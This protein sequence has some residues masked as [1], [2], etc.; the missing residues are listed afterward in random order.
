MK[1]TAAC[2]SAALILLSC[3]AAFPVIYTNTIIPPFG[4]IVSYK[5]INYYLKSD[6]SVLISREALAADSQRPFYYFINMDTLTY[7]ITDE[8]D[9]RKDF[10]QTGDG[11]DHKF[12]RL[13]K[14]ISAR[15][16]PF[17]TSGQ[18]KA[19]PDSNPGNMT[20]IVLTSDLCPTS[21]HFARRFYESLSEYGK[22][23]GGPVRIVIFFS[24]RWLERHP[25]DLR[26]IKKFPINFIAGNH[27]YDHPIIS[28]GYLREFLIG[29]VTNTEMI[30][31]ENGL[32]PSYF[33]R[34]PG[35]RHTASDIK[36]LD[37]INITAIDANAWMGNNFTNWNVLLVHSNGNAISE[38]DA[39]T[40]FIQ[41]PVD[42][43]KFQGIF[44]LIGL[45]LPTV[46]LPAV[47]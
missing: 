28:G 30:M 39:F 3:S 6:P 29:E 10:T 46:R 43:I 25:E 2:V 8:W 26:E 22:K 7:G 9:I 27:T 19:L 33:F 23:S 35:L 41:G 13:K 4:K 12:T 47:K 42:G 34:F 32:L 16:R 15:E 44:S 18:D 20:N 11:Q 38:V 17:G 36:I 5:I 1:F 14:I 40:N 31:L 37:S 21:K 45:Y 24:G